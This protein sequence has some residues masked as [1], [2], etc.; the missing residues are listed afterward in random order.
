[1]Q[2]FRARWVF[3]DRSFK[4]NRLGDEMRYVNGVARKSIHLEL[5]QA[6]GDQPERTT[7]GAAELARTLG[8]SP[9]FV[10]AKLRPL[11]SAGLAIKHVSRSGRAYAISDEG[12]D[13]LLRVARSLPME[14]SGGRIS[15]LA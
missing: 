3:L 9:Q 12:R 15:R 8:M 13:Y 10:V 7:S 2:V 14:T 1:M 6:L 5:L 11:L 4:S